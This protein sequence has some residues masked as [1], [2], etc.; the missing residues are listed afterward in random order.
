MTTI[1]KAGTALTAGIL[2]SMLGACDNGGNNPLTNP[3][4]Q[5][6]D[7]PPG[8]KDP[9]A[10]DTIQRYEKEDGTGNGYAQ[11]I[12]YNKATNTFTVDNLAFDAANEYK[13]DDVVS[14][15]GSYRVYENDSPF[16]DSVTG[17]P[18]T[19]FT[20]KAILGISKNTTA[21]GKPET[22]FAVV[23]TGSYAGYGFG[24]FMY[25]RNG[26][27]VLPDSGQAAFRG[28]YAGL[29]DFK[30]QSGLEYV[31]G[32][33]VLD[34]DF[35]DFNAGDGVKGTIY[36]RKIFDLD[37]NDITNQ[38]TRAIN[39]EYSVSLPVATVPNLYFTV[40]PKTL[41]SSGELTN[42]VTNTLSGKLFENGKYFAV[43]SGSGKDMEVVGIVVVESTH[44]ENKNIGIR[45]TGGFI[46]YR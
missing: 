41:D 6:D 44:P 12:T 10:G 9:G 33:M 36:N 17:T 15:L 43:L 38:Y 5:N 25:E 30:G 29:R 26:G 21:D 34:I 42:G 39:S 24:G 7:L 46:L 37:G 19:Q 18:I 13:Q 35:N 20:H 28:D 45:E 4:V 40:G 8:T 1:L 23:R 27:V 11:S 32:D 22:Q 31:T 16:A 3:A 2:L 14:T